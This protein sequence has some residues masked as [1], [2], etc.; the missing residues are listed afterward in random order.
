MPGSPVRNPRELLDVDVQQLAG[1]AAL[2]AVGQLGRLEP[3][4]LAQPDAQQHRRD[5]RERH[6][7]TQRDLGAGHPQAP[8][9]DD[10]LDAL[11]GRALPDPGRHRGTAKRPASPSVRQRRPHFEQ[12]RSLTS[13]AAAAFVTDHPCS[14]T[15]PTI[16]RR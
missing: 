2:V 7:Q 1:V 14:T 6:P 8:Q 16:R 5:R 12:V 13:A 4:E 3:A 11:L 15:R 9:R 10:D